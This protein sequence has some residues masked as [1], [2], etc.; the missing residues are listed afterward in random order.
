MREMRRTRRR[1]LTNVRAPH[2]RGCSSRT[3]ERRPGAAREW[4]RRGTAGSS[5]D[6]KRR[7]PR[8]APGFAVQR[9]R[10]PRAAGGQVSPARGR[11]TTC[12][13]A[14]THRR[15]LPNFSQSCGPPSRPPPYRLCRGRGTPSAPPPSLAPRPPAPGRAE[16][17]A[18]AADGGAGRPRGPWRRRS[19]AARRGCPGC[20]HCAAPAA[21]RP[22]LPAGPPPPRAAPAAGGTARPPP[23]RLVRS[24]ATPGVASQSRPRP[25]RRPAPRAEVP[26]AGAAAAPRSKE[27]LRAATLGAAAPVRRQAPGTFLPSNGGTRREMPC[28]MVRVPAARTAAQILISWS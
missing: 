1:F 22:P 21:P 11:Q 5:R 12:P 14:R 17:E 6:S 23:P 19:G 9:G 27:P 15:R 24:A 3:A 20:G 26:R 13:A 28:P 16:V 8:S 2:A 25:R 7:S 18:T 4:E 10:E